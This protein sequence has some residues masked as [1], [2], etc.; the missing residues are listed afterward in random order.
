MKHVHDYEVLSE[1]ID[2]IRERCKECGKILI[3]TK[4]RNDRINNVK[5]LK[6]HAR[7]FAQPTGRTSRLYK[8]IYG[9]ENNL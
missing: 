9:K 7:D 8:K 2:G 6:E 5:Y 1:S 4:G 3:T